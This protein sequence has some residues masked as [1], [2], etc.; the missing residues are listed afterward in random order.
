M[1]RDT[2]KATRFFVKAY[3]ETDQKQV[4]QAR[5]RLQKATAPESKLVK[6]INQYCV[7]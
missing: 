7:Q 3:K 5:Q 6:E 4:K 1:Y 2:A